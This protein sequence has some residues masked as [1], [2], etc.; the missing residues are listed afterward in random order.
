MLMDGWRSIHS[1][2]LFALLDSV[3][4]VQYLMKCV[5]LK[6]QNRELELT[7]QT[8]ESIGLLLLLL[9]KKRKE[10]KKT[11]LLLEYWPCS[12]LGLDSNRGMFDHLRWWALARNATATAALE[13]NDGPKWSSLVELYVWAG[14]NLRRV[15]QNEASPW[16]GNRPATTTLVLDDNWIR[17]R[18]LDHCCRQSCSSRVDR[19][20]LMGPMFWCREDR[21]DCPPPWTGRSKRWTHWTWTAQRIEQ[22]RNWVA[23][24]NRS[25][26][27]WHRV[28]P[29]KCLGGWS[30]PDADQ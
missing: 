30:N 17:V 4:F 10:K 23:T 26:S 20:N 8:F 27:E 2:E 18:W 29:C 19:T 12:R 13:W 11:V 9:F 1:A 24:G 6:K 25:R 14:R 5:N 22:R 15:V 3:Q 16:G 28:N 21:E 7:P